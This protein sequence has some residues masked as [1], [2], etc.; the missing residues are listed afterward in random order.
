ME[1]SIE[2]LERIHLE[3]EN[4]GAEILNYKNTVLDKSNERK[5]RNKK[6]MFKGSQPFF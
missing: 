6:V 4:L 1:Q 5:T 3:A 2:E